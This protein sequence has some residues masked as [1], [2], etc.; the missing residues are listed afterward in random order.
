M[1]VHQA[2]LNLH[3]CAQNAPFCRE[4]PLPCLSMGKACTHP[5]N[6]ASSVKPFLIFPGKLFPSLLHITNIIFTRS[7]CKVSS[8]QYLYFIVPRVSQGQELRFISHRFPQHLT[9]CME[10]ERSENIFAKCIN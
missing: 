4:F 5:S 7:Y 2:N 8:C 3:F 10:C 1:T 6:A 9:Q